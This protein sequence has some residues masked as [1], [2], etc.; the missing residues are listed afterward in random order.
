LTPIMMS[1]E[2]LRANVQDE[3]GHRLLDTLLG[4]AQHGA[5]MVKQILSFTRGMS[6]EKSPLQLKHLVLEM[7]QIAKD[8]FS[9]SIQIQ[10][11]VPTG[12]WS[13]A[14][15]RTQMHQVLMNL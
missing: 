13:V 15:D 3:R 14:G 6:G 7:Q 9:R 1:V 2:L 11:K 5:E 4:S 10:T 8:T 12:L